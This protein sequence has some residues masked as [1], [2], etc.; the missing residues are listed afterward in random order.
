MFWLEMFT[1]S[2]SAF[3]FGSSNTS[4]HFPR[5][6]SSRGS[7]CFHSRD[8]L[9]FAGSGAEGALYFGPTLHDASK[10]LKQ[11]SN[12]LLIYSRPLNPAR[13]ETKRKPVEIEVDHRCR[14]E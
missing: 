12:F 10:R 5:K 1:C 3:N 9:K 6:M 11:T 7:A 13:S 8:S 14:I 2:S 4:H